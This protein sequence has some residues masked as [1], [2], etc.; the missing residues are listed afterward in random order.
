LG[1][2]LSKIYTR[3]G[4]AGTTGLADGSRVDKD[5]PRVEAMGAVDELNSVI[6]VILAQEIPTD[7][8]ECLAD[9]QHTLF[10][11]GGELAI[12]GASTVHQ[13]HVDTVE[14]SLDDL[15]ATLPPLKEFILPGGGGPAAT[16][17]VARA[18]C[19]RAERR[20]LTLAHDED[21]N[22]HSRTYLNRLS[23]LMFVMAR[24]LARARGSEVYWDPKRNTE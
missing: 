8:R 6:G 15:N 2:R 9:V 16:T 7:L 14:A 3:T 10:D 5:S 12:P 20:L 13:G 17:H 24:V 1:N 4:D 23:D 21:V 22:Q 19:R 11:I 18:V